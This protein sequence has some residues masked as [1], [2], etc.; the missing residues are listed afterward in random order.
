MVKRHTQFLSDTLH[1]GLKKCLLIMNYYVLQDPY[2]DRLVRYCADHGSYQGCALP[3]PEFHDN[4]DNALQYGNKQKFPS[5]HGD[6]MP[7][8]DNN[9]AECSNDTPIQY[10]NE[11][12]WNEFT[13]Y[14]YSDGADNWGDDNLKMYSNET[15]WGD[16]TVEQHYNESECFDVAENQPDSNAGWNDNTS[17]SNFTNVDSTESGSSSY[18]NQAERKSPTLSSTRKASDDSSM[19]FMPKASNFGWND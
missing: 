8:E 10:T 19:Y 16:H 7:N 13:S 9:V 6:K 3:P 2:W 14:P 12:E 18:S 4:F 17:E 1:N 5:G 15:E 11:V